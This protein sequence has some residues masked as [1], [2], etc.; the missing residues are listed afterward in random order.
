MKALLFDLDGTL[1]DT[2]EVILT[3]MQ[4]AYSAVLGKETLPSDDELLSMVGIPLKTQMEM[5][6]P[7]KSDAL[8]AAYQEHNKRVQ[9]T[10]KGFEGTAEALTALKKRGIRMGVVTS[11]RH[12]PAVYG[13]ELM[14]LSDFFECVL[15]SDDT[16]EHKPEPG[17]LLDAVKLMG[18]STQE[19]AYIGDSPYDMRA[20]RAA[21]LYA[22]GVSWGMFTEDVLLEAGAEVIVSH[23]SELET[24]LDS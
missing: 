3:S 20:A 19:C 12:D 1:L 16:T 14:G 5:L 24:L 2:R 23:M 8:F 15:G 10:T 13:L 21:D 6:S 22:V 11:K 9:H 18:L 4:Y 7:E 17:P